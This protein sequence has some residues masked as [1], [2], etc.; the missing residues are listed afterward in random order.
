MVYSSIKELVEMAY[1]KGKKI[2]QVARRLEAQQ[3]EKREDELIRD[4][5]KMYEIMVSAME[6][7][8]KEE[9]RSISGLTGGEGK[10]LWES[11][12]KRLTGEIIAKSMARAMA[13]SNVNAGM[14]RIVA[15]PTAGAGGILPAV[16]KTVSE[17]NKNTHQETIDALF[18]AGAI[19]KVIAIRA[20]LSGAEGG[21]QAECGAG[22]AMAAAS[23][24]ELCGGSPGEVANAVAIVL[25]SIM[26]LVCDPVAGLVEVP[27][28]KRNG[29]YA[30]IAISGAF[31]ALSGIESV[32]PADEVIDAMKEVGNAL[33]HTLKETALG[34]IAQTPTA[35]EITEKLRRRSSYKKEK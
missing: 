16:V 6:K 18:T 13:I 24:T 10:K 9:I 5:E 4:M 8:T 28:I 21:C 1:Q 31:M 33:P 15:A 14:G 27:C 34:G 11:D 2:G 7:G 20:T 30:S 25:K 19:G 22:A 3:M 23:A 35:L 32:I 17:A 29:M 12:K 26:G